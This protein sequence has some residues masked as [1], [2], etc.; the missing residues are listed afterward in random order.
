MTFDKQS[1]MREYRAKNRA[2]LNERNRKWMAKKRKTD[3]VYAAK[4]RRQKREAARMRR[5]SM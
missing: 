4:E 1:Y 3:P 5:M 2:K